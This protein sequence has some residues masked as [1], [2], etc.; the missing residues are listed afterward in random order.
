[1]LPCTSLCTRL[2]SQQLFSPGPRLHHIT[3][4]TGQ[5]TWWLLLIESADIILIRSMHPTCWKGRRQCHSFASSSAV[6][7]S[8]ELKWS[9]SNDALHPILRV[10][11]EPGSLLSVK[12]S[13]LYRRQ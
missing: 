7:N 5:Q 10:A 1:M 6:V 12:Q 9:V 13:R 11:C 4:C 8:V 2:Y 3:S